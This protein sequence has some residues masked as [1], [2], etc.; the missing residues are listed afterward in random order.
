M[1]IVV[2]NGP[3]LNA[4]GTRD[5]E[6]YG[7]ESLADVERLCAQTAE[8]LGGTVTCI[9]SNSEGALVDAIQ[10]ARGCE[11]LVINAGAYSHTSIAIH[12]ALEL[13]D[14][15][16]IEV[17]VSQVFARED[18]RHHSYISRQASG[19]IVGLGIRGYAMALEAIADLLNVSIADP[20]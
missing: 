3:N 4:L 12:D 1:K 11:G 19:V 2:I 13:I 7:A 5:P 8:R 10:A 9:Q 17:H 6:V 20:S 14:A 15:P 18:F 16:V